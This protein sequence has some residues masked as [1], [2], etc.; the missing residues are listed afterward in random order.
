MEAE[1]KLP[2]SDS[3]RYNSQ[4]AFLVKYERLILAKHKNNC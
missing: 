1:H 2:Q 4:S 3:D